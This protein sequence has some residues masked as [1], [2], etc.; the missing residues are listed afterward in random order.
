MIEICE[1]LTLIQISICLMIGLFFGSLIMF[2]WDYKQKRAAVEKIHDLEQ[3]IDYY[4]S[5]HDKYMP[6]EK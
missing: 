2:I 5:K 3:I 1:V 4:V 6:H